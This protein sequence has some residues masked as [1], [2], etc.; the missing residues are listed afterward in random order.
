MNNSTRWVY[1]LLLYFGFFST[2]LSAQS[3]E[4]EK[5]CF[6]FNDL[7]D[8][9][10]FGAAA[11]QKPGTPI[12]K[13]GGVIVSLDSFFSFNSREFLNVNVEE[14]KLLFDGSFTDAEGK[15]L[16]V[17]NVNLKWVFKALPKGKAKRIC[18]NFI[19]GGGEENFSVNGQ[20]VVILEDWASLDGKEVAKGVKVAVSIEDDSKLLQGSICFE[21]ELDSISFGGQEFGIDNVCIEYE[22]EDDDDT[23]CISDLKV[24]PRPC[25]P[26]NI[27]YLAATFKASPKTDTSTY[28]VW[29]NK[30]KFGPFKYKDVFP[31][32][33]PVEINSSGKY[34]L[35][36]QDSVDPKCQESEDF[37]YDCNNT[38]ACSLQN[39]EASISYC[40]RDTFATLIVELG[41]AEPKTG[42]ITLTLAGVKIGDYPVE[43]L[44]FRIP[45][46]K[47][48]FTITASPTVLLQACIN[49]PNGRCCL[50]TVPKIK[51]DPSCPPDPNYCGIKEFAAQPLCR[52]DGSL[53]MIYKFDGQNKGLSGFYLYVNEQRFGPYRYAVNG[54]T[55]GPI[56]PNADGYYRV[57]M[58]DVENAKCADT[59][60]IKKF[61][62]Q[63]C[64]I[65]ELRAAYI[66]CEKEKQDIFTLNFAHSAT[67][68]TAYTLQ[69]NG[70]AIGTFSLKKLPLRISISKA[71]PNLLGNALKVRVC[72]R[73]VDNCCLEAE[74]KIT[75]VASCADDPNL[76]P[77]KEAAASAVACANTTKFA[78]DIKA[79]FDKNLLSNELAFVKINNRRYGPFKI[80]SFPIRLE[81]IDLLNST[82]AVPR[83][84]VCALGLLDTCCVTIIPQIK[85]ED[86]SC[87]LDMTVTPVDCIDTKYFASIKVESRNG[88]KSGYVVVGP[89]GKKYGPYGYNERPA[90][91]GPFLRSTTSPRQIFYAVDV[92][93]ACADTVVLEKIV[94]ANDTICLLRDV[95]AVVRGCN[96]KGGYDL[97]ITPVVQLL[98]TATTTYTVII[99]GKKYG[100]FKLANTPQL[101]ENVVI[102]TDALTF[103]VR[104]CLDGQSERCC[105][106]VK[107]SKPKCP[108]CELGEM[109]VKPLECNDKGEFYAYIDFKYARTGSDFFVLEQAGKAPVKYKYSELPIK[110]GPFQSPLKESVVFKAYDSNLPDCA[111]KGVLQPYE[112]KRPCAIEAVEVSE[113]RCNND[114]T[115]SM[116]LKVKGVN[117][118]S[119]LWLQTSSGFETRFK[120]TGQAVRIDKIPVPK[121]DRFDWL[122]LCSRNDQNCCYKWRYEV[123]CTPGTC[124]FGPLKLEQVCLPTGGYYV[125]LN[126][127]HKNTGNQ[128]NVYVNGKLYGTFAYNLLPLRISQLVNIDPAVLEIKIEDKEKGC[129]QSGRL[130]LKVCESNCPIGSIKVEALPC[131]NGQLYVKAQVVARPTSTLQKGYIIYANGALFGPFA[132]NGEAQ[133]IG[134]FA[135]TLGGVIEFLA[136]DVTNPTCFAS[137]KLEIKPCID[138]VPCKISDLVVKGLACNP[139]GSRRLFINFKY[140]G[141]TNR[142][143]NLLVDG[144]IIGTFQLLRLPLESNFKLAQDKDVYKISVCINDQRSCCETVEV[145]LPCPRPCPD[146]IVDVKQG[147]CNAGGAF[148]AELL[149]KNPTPG[150]LRIAI[151]GR[152]LDTLEAGKTRFNL[153]MLLGDGVTLYKVDLLNLKDTTCKR[154]L[155]FG[156]VKCRNNRVSEVWPGDVNQDNIANHFD[157][158]HIGQAYGAKGIKRF[159][160]NAWDWKAYLAENWQQIF[161]DAINY[162]HA[163][164][165]GDGEINRKDID[166]LKDNFGKTRGAIKLPQVLPATD[167]DP[168]IEVAMPK[169]GEL[170]N[171]AAFDIPINLGDAK[172]VIKDIYGVAF[173]VK[174]DPKL[175]DPSALNVEFPTSWMGQ[176]GVNLESIY[177][178]Y[179]N[180]GR[181]DI[182]ITRTDQNEVSGYG[183]VARMKG[184]IIDL[185]GRSETKLQTE[186]ALL[187]RLDGELLP[188]NVHSTG[189]SVVD[190]P[191]QLRPEDL[192]SGVSVYP[193]PTNSQINISTVTGTVTEV[194]VM[195]LDG[196][197]MLKTFRN[198][199]QL[200]LDDLKA[201]M[202]FLRIKVGEQT[203]F[204]RVI[205]Q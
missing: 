150:P 89:D 97:L 66:I 126:V 164:V 61:F 98:S 146:L 29:V 17:S 202:Y 50:S 75:R 85:Y 132:Y 70:I 183:T 21:G 3:Q 15:V 197:T 153:G 156:P 115:Y 136:V 37:D 188:L 191:R 124:E 42:M 45:I 30:Q 178:I 8:K 62:C 39:L 86:C 108:A 81:G 165:N 166:A 205:K 189:F 53:S 173:S 193:N 185:V 52:E 43:K 167:L 24:L 172:R 99:E 118:D 33:G 134:P 141:V 105:F 103:E 73:G 133:K 18:F 109:L 200:D 2:Q 171:N 92:E 111:T 27:F 145:K 88:S 54:G 194:E 180:E 35:T 96:V 100:P 101:I 67:I 44:P 63:P 147:S 192:L 107:V 64:T 144:K 157:L 170:A 79:G 182:A 69:I 123:P 5:V 135:G 4:Q 77:V 19:D 9:T 90:V 7:P 186:D 155:T 148:G 31:A 16:F 176:Q 10:K 78:I 46:S 84:E 74:A 93:K 195:A 177:K 106:S 38:N 187:N 149:F 23:D 163:D 129:T 55:V 28:F 51:L 14:K 119:T 161:F 25:T 34:L 196:K 184:I 154:L 56:R 95:R 65:K 190:V 158:L 131:E 159:V 12:L 32:I 169:Q 76:C 114:G 26:N 58:V 137:T 174:F 125:S 47:R 83:I 181:I 60:E 13:Q 104:V 41:K 11:N 59:V 120:F 113:I 151:N 128:F 48:F 20:K 121:N 71:I 162:K 22:E 68:D 116:L 152:I 94:C 203:F 49:L 201:G 40:A 117:L 110:V 199:N 80:S 127:E 36:I 122:V 112:C 143:F 87:K 102:A 142:F 175:I 82:T 57:V 179:P 140:S 138:P 130:P 204:E 1:L 6:N 160:E 91:I 198:T 72:L 139:D 168:K